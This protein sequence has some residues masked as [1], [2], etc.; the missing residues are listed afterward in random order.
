MPG[1]LDSRL[2]PWST[3][4]ER[5]PWDAEQNTTRAR[6]NISLAYGYPVETGLDENSLTRRR[7]IQPYRI[8]R[9]QVLAEAVRSALADMRDCTEA[10]P[11][12]LSG[13]LVIRDTRFTV[14]QL[15]AELAEGRDI[16]DIS[17]AFTVRQDLI[18]RFLYGLSTY[19]NTP[20]R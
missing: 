19:L 17:T 3:E 9:E 20:V 7:H 1:K 8:S 16:H 15:L 6:D 4:E 13:V 18:E 10:H 5:A 11:A 12:K 14:A 2:A